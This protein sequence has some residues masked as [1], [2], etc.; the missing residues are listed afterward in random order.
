ILTRP[1]DCRPLRYLH[2]GKL[3]CRSVGFY[4]SNSYCGFSLVVVEPHRG[5]SCLHG[6]PG[7]H[8]IPAKPNRRSDRYIERQIHRTEVSRGS[9]AVTPEPHTPRSSP[10][11]EINAHSSTGSRSV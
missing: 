8:A 9:G 2:A 3:D 1:D 6:R 11:C 4:R 5:T 7:T 10:T